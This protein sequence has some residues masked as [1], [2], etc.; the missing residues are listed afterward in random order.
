MATKI[1]SQL[2]EQSAQSFGAFGDGS[3][4]PLSVD[5]A[6]AF[7]AAY[8][9]IGLTAVAGDETDWAA[10]QALLLTC[11]ISGNPANL[12]PGT[13]L[14]NKPLTMAWIPPSGGPPPVTGQPAIPLLGLIRGAGEKATTIRGLISSAG[15]GII[16]LLGYANFNAVKCE[17]SDLTIIAQVGSSLTSW[18]L[19]VGDAFDGFLAR[20]VYCQG[21]NGVDLITHAI[22]VIGYSHSDTRFEG[23]AFFCNYFGEY[24]SNEATAAVL[25]VGYESTGGK[26][27]NVTFASCYFFGSVCPLANT[28][29]FL[30]CVFATDQN[31]PVVAAHNYNACLD[32]RV[33]QATLI[34]CYFEDY[35]TAV[36]VKATAG[37]VRGLTILGGWFG[38]TNNRP[39]TLPQYGVRVVT[40]YG[41]HKTGCVT[42]ERISTNTPGH[43]I[44]DFSLPNGVTGAIRFCTNITDPNDFITY[45]HSGGSRLDVIQQHFSGSTNNAFRESYMNVDAFHQ[46]QSEETAA[47][48]DQDGGPTKGTTNGYDWGFRLYNADATGSAGLRWTS[49]H[50]TTGGAYPQ[51]GNNDFG[52]LLPTGQG[53]KICFGTASAADFIQ[54]DINAITTNRAVVAGT[55]VNAGTAVVAGTSVSAGTFVSATDHVEA[56]VYAKIPQTVRPIKTV[57]VDTPLVLGDGYVR[58]TGVAGKTITLMSCGAVGTDSAEVIIKNATGVTVHIA[59]HAGDSIENGA[60]DLAANTSVILRSNGGTLWEY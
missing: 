37:D 58:F 49:T 34:E 18:C 46:I 42:L 17:L 11:G 2:V 3:S 32:L 38:A 33:G 50:Y 15:R 1:P 48:P 55:S 26:W 22:D 13:F 19:R 20:N 9:P 43:V 53:W 51:M 31:R 56:G 14:T 59:A 54:F 41:V 8:G 24:I 4:H 52:M 27:D 7:N 5:G 36:Y 21:I 10:I 39:G 29:L 23:C 35:D 40:N 16:E 57:T 12:G 6:A 47:V 30:N 45:D 28:L 44:S 25:A 60:F